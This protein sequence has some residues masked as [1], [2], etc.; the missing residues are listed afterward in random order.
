MLSVNES[1]STDIPAKRLEKVDRM[2]RKARVNSQVQ[3][4]SGRSGMG[5]IR[6]LIWVSAYALLKT[7]MSGSIPEG[8]RHC[9]V[10]FTSDSA[11]QLIT[12]SFTE[13]D[14]SL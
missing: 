14:K 12:K 9:R 2:V 1:Q 5:S 8:R 3:S 7:G 4:Y 11:Y 10:Q 6:G 13:Q